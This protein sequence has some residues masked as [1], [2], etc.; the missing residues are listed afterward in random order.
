MSAFASAFTFP[1][2]EELWTNS[3][4]AEG[5]RIMTSKHNAK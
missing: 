4:A 5:Q 2:Q 1:Q 3:T